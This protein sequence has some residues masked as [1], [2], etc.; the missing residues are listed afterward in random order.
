[1]KLTKEETGLLYL[2]VAEAME[3]L[4]FNSYVNKQLITILYKLDQ[5]ARK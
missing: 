1:M 2:L 5:E 4:N 3:K